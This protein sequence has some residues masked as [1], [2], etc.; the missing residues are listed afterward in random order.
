MKEITDNIA[1]TI[2]ALMVAVSNVNEQIEEIET[3]FF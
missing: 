3:E 2:S 1:K